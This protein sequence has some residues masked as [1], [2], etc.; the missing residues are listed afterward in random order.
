MSFKFKIKPKIK[1]GKLIKDK[2]ME[3]KSINTKIEYEKE[4]ED[5]ITFDAKL[6][7]DL[8]YQKTEL[9]LEDRCKSIKFSFTKKF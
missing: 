4:L 2:E 6:E 7:M 1:L 8:N 9:G 3:F 5:G